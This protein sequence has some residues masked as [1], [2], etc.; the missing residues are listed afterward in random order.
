M[1]KVCRRRR[2]LVAVLRDFV[3]EMRKGNEIDGGI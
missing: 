2:V 3:G 1:A